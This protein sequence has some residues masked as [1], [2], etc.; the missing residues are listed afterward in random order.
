[1]Q[2]LLTYSIFKRL[3]LNSESVSFQEILNAST[4]GDLSR[5]EMA[6]DQCGDINAL[7]VYG[8]TALY[9]ASLMGHREV[10]LALLS[11]NATDVNK[12]N[13]IGRTP[14]HAA[15]ANAT[16]QELPAESISPIYYAASPASLEIVEALLSDNRTDV[17]SQ[18]SLGWTPLYAASKEGGF[19]RQVLSGKSWHF[20]YVVS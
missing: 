7:D 19:L 17:N 16:P 12:A 18:D 13:S 1:M 20:S 2:F 14:L 4:A 8:Y 11:D 10:V 15:S 3:A 9:W 5:A 6:L